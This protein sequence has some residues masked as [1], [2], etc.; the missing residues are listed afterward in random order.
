MRQGCQQEEVRTLQN[1][2][3]VVEVIFEVEDS[4]VRLVSNND[5]AVN[6]HL[7]EVADGGDDE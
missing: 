1:D 3:N 4:D 7:E 6:V 5:I 2:I